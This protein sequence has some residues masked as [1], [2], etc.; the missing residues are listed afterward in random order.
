V[1]GPYNDQVGSAASTTYTLAADLALYVGGG[2]VHFAGQ[3]LTGETI[4]GGGGNITAG[5]VSTARNDVEVEYDYTPANPTPEP[6]S[7]ALSGTGLLFLGLFGRRRLSR[8]R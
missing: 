6:F 3:T 2:T 4:M 8:I 5:M 1:Y 7:I